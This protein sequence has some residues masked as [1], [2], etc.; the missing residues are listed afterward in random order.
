M[1]ENFEKFII[2]GGEK[3][4]KMYGNFKYDNLLLSALLNI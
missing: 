4:N 1:R 2:F 3:Q